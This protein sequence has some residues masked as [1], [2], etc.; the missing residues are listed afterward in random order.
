MTT[1][2]NLVEKYGV[3]LTVDN[4]SEI[5]QRKPAGLRW[6]LSQGCNDPGLEY[7]RSS[8]VRIGRK[9]YFPT[10]A[11]AKLI[12]GTAPLNHSESENSSARH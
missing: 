1:L 2:E 3:L 9:I 10:E 6:S 7:L 5:L 8:I 12:D 4:V 11:L